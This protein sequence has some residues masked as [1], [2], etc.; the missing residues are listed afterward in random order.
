MESN[1][2]ATLLVIIA[3]AV[4]AYFLMYHPSKQPTP[5]QTA[6]LVTSSLF[7]GYPY[8]LPISMYRVIYT[9]DRASI[10]T[11]AIYFYVN[12]TIPQE[13]VQK[14]DKLV[15]EYNDTATIFPVVYAAANDQVNQKFINV[16]DPQDIYVLQRDQYGVPTKIQVTF[17]TADVPSSDNY[18][19]VEYNAPYSETFNEL[20][21]IALNTVTV[22][23][24]WHIYKINTIL[25]IQPYTST[26]Y[27]QW[28][29]VFYLSSWC[30]GWVYA[31]AYKLVNIPV[32]PTKPLY[33]YLLYYHNKKGNGYV[34]LGLEF[35]YKNGTKFIVGFGTNFGTV[36]G[37]ST[38]CQ[39]PAIASG[40][41]VDVGTLIKQYCH[42]IDWLNVT[43]IR[44]IFIDIHNEGVTYDYGGC[45]L[46]DEILALIHV[47]NGKA[48]KELTS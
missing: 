21:P 47:E 35:E 33:T 29:R 37:V 38:I 45:G 32:D 25:H 34:H 17:K 26:N 18:I 7:E 40:N 22:W 14:L 41:L 8:R 1:R 10:P 27:Y 9:Y 15:A 20:E 5:Y 16:V 44:A 13:I 42:G 2:L 12:I 19:I 48:I 31:L 11:T 30:S 28:F 23:D 39:A 24:G 36:N 46:G 3:L 4:G 6:K 43:S